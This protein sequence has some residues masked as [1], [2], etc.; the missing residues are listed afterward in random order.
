M[1]TIHTSHIQYNTP[2]TQDVWYYVD[3]TA[4][5]YLNRC[6]YALCHHSIPDYAHLHR[7]IYHR[8]IPLG[9]LPS[10]FYRQLARQVETVRADP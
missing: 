3:Q 4:R 5:T 2:K 8:G 10:I 6:L 1:D 7:Q 9:G